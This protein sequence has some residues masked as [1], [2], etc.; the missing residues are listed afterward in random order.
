MLAGAFTRGVQDAFQKFGLALPQ[1]STKALTQGH[2]LPAPTTLPAAP[3]QAPSPVSAL[4]KEAG[5]LERLL[6]TEQSL[7]P[8]GARHFYGWQQGRGAMAPA[9]P[10]APLPRP[11]V[12][13]TV[14]ID[15]GYSSQLQHMGLGAA[16]A[17]HASNVGMG[18][19]TSTSGTGATRGEPPDVG[20]RQRSV[21]DRT[22]QQNDDFFASSSM[23]APGGN[24]SP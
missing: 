2:S 18:A 10:A 9:A 6:M 23:P 5:A 15:P 21:I 11:T 3:L 16:A 13:S 20:R 7:G 24:V 22:F 14:H 12:P 4:G 17:K 19:S 1:Q 8:A